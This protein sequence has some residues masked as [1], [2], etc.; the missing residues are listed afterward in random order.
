[1]T[2]RWD[3]RGSDLDADLAEGV[4]IGSVIDAELAEDPAEAAI[5]ARMLQESDENDRR[6]AM[7]LAA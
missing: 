6:Y 1:M 5:V 4:D 2:N 7:S 3:D